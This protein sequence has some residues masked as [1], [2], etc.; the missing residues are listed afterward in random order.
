MLFRTATVF[1][2]VVGAIQCTDGKEAQKACYELEEALPELVSRRLQ[3]GDAGE[4]LDFWSLTVQDQKPACLVRPKT[5]QDVAE[6]VKILN[7]HPKVQF[8][9]KSGGHDPNPGHANVNGGVLVSLNDMKGATFNEK[10]KVA[11]VKPGGEWNDPLGDLAE[12]GVAVVGGRLGVVGV[13]GLVLQGGIS[14]LSA[15]T[16]FA[17]D[18]VLEWE[19]VRAD[20]SIVTISAE[21]DP[22]LATAMR[23]SGSQ[24]G[25]VTQ[26]TMKTVPVGQEVWGGMRMYAADQVDALF[27][28]L[29]DFI[30]ANNEDVKAAIIPTDLTAAGGPPLF[31]VFYFYHDA[32]PPTEGALANFLEIPS[33]L[34]TT[35]TQSYAGL[36]QANGASA[37]LQSARQSFRT[38]TV[39]YVADAPH[40]YNEISLKFKSIIDDFLKSAVR[41]TTQCSVAFQPF[42]SIIAKHSQ[43][44]GGNAMGIH[45][46]DGDR[47]I[48]ETQCSWALPSDDELVREMSKE[49]EDWLKTKVP[50]WT[51]GQVDGLYLPYFMNDAAGDQNVTGTYRDYAALK[52]LQKRN[53][54]EGFWS[55][56][57]G[58]HKY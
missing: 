24:F 44:A 31:L 51:K 40:M 14:F 52:A 4:I 17:A 25:I 20:G 38:F 19:T 27:S 42:P 22:E 39:P 10:K 47:L 54:P 5:T 7:K 21:S 56:R 46:D 37:G 13:G 33:T 18:T 50:Q 36:L 32:E 29:H 2:A 57:A 6:T 53:D 49:M 26:F 9:V 45:P 28:A 23:G 1:A 34:D 48:I 35:K 8:A 43:E 41:P 58:G 12:A 3:L 30:P 16:G 11:C 55:A 15:Q